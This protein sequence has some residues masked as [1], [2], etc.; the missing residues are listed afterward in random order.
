MNNFGEF[1]INQ[2][3]RLSKI[4]YH[5]E[6]EFGKSAIL[7]GIVV[8]KHNNIVLLDDGHKLNILID[9]FEIINKG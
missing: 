8:M 3:K 4:K 2:I 7:T 6:F 5:R 9:K 1:M